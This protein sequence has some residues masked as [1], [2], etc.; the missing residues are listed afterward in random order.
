MIVTDSARTAKELLE[1]QSI[2]VVLCGLDLGHE[3]GIEFLEVVHNDWP[4]TQGLLMCSASDLPTLSAF[5]PTYG[6][7]NTPWTRHDLNEQ[8]LA[9]FQRFE[10]RRENIELRKLAHSQAQQLENMSHS[11]DAK[12][13]HRTQQLL[14]AKVVWE[15][16]FDAIVDPVAIISSEHEVLRAN[17]AYADHS[18]L[19]VSQVPGKK[20]FELV[21]GT[22]EP[23]EKC[24]M[25]QGD[26]SARGVDIEARHNRM[27]HVW[28]YPMPISD[29]D[30]RYVEKDSFVCYY[31]DVTE[32]R[33]LE[34][35]LHQSEKLASLG[36]FV[37]GVAHEVN[38]PLASIKLLTESLRE[39]LVDND[40]G[41]EVLHDIEVSADRC[42]RIIDSLRSFVHGSAK[43]HKESIQVDEIV[44]EV[45]RIFIRDYGTTAQIDCEI[46][47]NLT[48]I[49]GDVA[50]LH[51]LFRNLLQ[52][53]YHS[54]PKSE[55]LIQI[56]IREG[57]KNDETNRSF[58]TVIIQDNGSGISKQ[59]LRH[60]FEPF[61]TTKSENKLGSGLGLSICHQ[62]VTKHRGKISV[63]SEVGEG[64][65]FIIELP[66]GEATG[67]FRL[68][69]LEE[70]RV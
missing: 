45:V 68:A 47:E 3:S 9:A 48:P 65:R 13:A 29:P 46:D 56:K 52:N 30:E 1:L 24:P 44:E 58:V 50:L 60:L 21:A 32:E 61:F 69:D 10:L 34:A 38:S 51:Q 7:L 39:E 40:D 12:I 11:V 35:K 28:S 37:G 42:R 59:N 63:E 14:N 5:E 31:R 17:L 27:L 20:C 8:L 54:L 62:I 43:L 66:V 57:S 67:K 36:L 18:Q 33:E 6:I 70:A 49:R 4:T 2:G 53:A 23:C 15:R 19:P 41:L 55:G 64:T 26:S 16:T 22:S 25:T